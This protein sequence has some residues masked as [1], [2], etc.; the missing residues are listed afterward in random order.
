MA[1]ETETGAGRAPMQPHLFPPKSAIDLLVFEC[2]SVAHRSSRC[3][4]NLQTPEGLFV[5]LRRVR[6]FSVVLVTKVSSRGRT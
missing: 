4:A 5:C 2:H 6:F 3:L 1:L